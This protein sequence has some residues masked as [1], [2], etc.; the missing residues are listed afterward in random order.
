MR[1]V[2]SLVVVLAAIAA[3][4]ICGMAR[5][6]ETPQVIIH[7]V[8]VVDTRTGELLEGRDVVMAGDRIIS[9][10]PSQTVLSDKGITLIDGHGKFLIPG[11]WDMQVH[12]SWMTGSALP[13]LVANGVTDVRDM[14]SQLDQIED[15]RTRIAG[16]LLVGPYI[17]RVG[18]MLN[19]KSFN[20]YQM[21]VGPTEQARGVVRTLKF[22]GMDGLSLERR[23][24]RD[25]YFALLDEAKREQIPVGGHIPIGIEPEEASDAGQAT[26]ENI[27]TLFEFMLKDGTAEEK[28]PGEIGKFLASGAADN[29]AAALRQDFDSREI[30]LRQ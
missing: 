17:L 29:G 10:E 1:H 25:S 5:A 18:P 19:G 4:A 15:W 27:D 21:V 8:T 11:L 20:Q 30:A 22:I 6:V 14:G 9:V 28:I 24:N 12:L 3:L 26:I 16:E 23:V 13:L 7:D 2:R